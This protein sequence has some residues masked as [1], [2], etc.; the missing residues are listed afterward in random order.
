[1]TEKEELLK[2]AQFG[3]S[4]APGSEEDAALPGEPVSQEERA[5]FAT[6]YLEQRFRRRAIDAVRQAGLSSDRF[7]EINRAL[8]A[9]PTE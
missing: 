3:N 2:I 7:T 4:L 5:G 8:N 1:M 6:A 9:D